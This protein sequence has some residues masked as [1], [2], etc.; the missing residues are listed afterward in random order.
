MFIWCCIPLRIIVRVYLFFFEEL[1]MSKKRRRRGV[2]LTE[3][4][5]KKLQ[6]AKSEAENS[7]NLDKEYT[8][9]NL[10][11][12]AGLDPDTLMKIF[13]RQV[14]VDKRSLNYCF[15][16]FNLELEATDYQFPQI[17][18]TIQNHKNSYPVRTPQTGC[19]ENCDPTVMQKSISATQK[20]DPQNII[21]NKI[22][23]GEAPDVSIF[24]GRQEELA[25]MEKWI[26][27]DRCR[28]LLLL[29][30]G[31]MGKTWLSAK[32]A[33][34]IQHNFDFVIWR[35]LDRVTSI[36]DMLAELIQFLSQEEETNL[37]ENIDSQISLLISY[38]KSSRCLLVLDN[39]ETIIENISCNYD[40]SG[41][42]EDYEIYNKFLKLM[43]QTPHQSCLLLT[44]R[45]KPKE[46]RQMEGE[47]LPVRVL[48]L[49]GLQLKD[50]KQMC[51]VKCSLYGSD[52][53]WKRII[54]HYGGNP[55][56]LNMVCATIQQLFDGQISDFTKHN[57]FVYGEIRHLLQQHFD[58]LSEIEKRIVC[59]LS[60]W[61]EP[62]SFSKLRE[63]LSPSISPQ[64]L[65][66]ATESLQ[67]RCLV[68]K[69][70]SLFSLQP[71]FRE[72]V[73]EQS[74]EKTIVPYL[75]FYEKQKK[76]L[77]HI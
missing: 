15:K 9:E 11:F 50:V 7:E 12:R 37:P 13:A 69:D 36:K 40:F 74:E 63:Y 5:Y 58:R 4:G 44:S 20:E 76:K 38:F 75:D 35:S 64:R 65:L 54:E 56:A 26:V 29:G 59:C 32:L 53:E 51:K 48:H 19:E 70:A 62:T 41:I 22:D 61:G 77:A 66:E 10:S 21:Q 49:K 17:D 2:I 24:Y 30:M 8:L 27:S 45:K 16:A 6:Q 73:N 71:L 14:G 46:T 55:L 57:I 3:K 67:E 43:A 68:E 52:S 33:E 25:T 42:N 18:K 39:V 34:Q 23:W 31:G 72:Y 47:K 60:R 28:V 1:I